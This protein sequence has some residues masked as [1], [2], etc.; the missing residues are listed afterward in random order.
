MDKT[1]EV[2]PDY[3]G[4][5]QRLRQRF[6]K[7]EGQDMADYELLELVLMMS[8]PRRD[9]KPLAKT[10]IKKFGSF[11]NTIN[12]NADDLLSVCGIKENS[13]TLIKVIKTA[14]LRTSWQS[15]ADSQQPVIANYDQLVEYCRQSMSFSDVEELRIIFL[16]CKMKIISQELMQKGT[17]N[18]VA[19]HP[20]EV[21]KAAM[22]KNASSIIMVHN[23]PSGDVTPSKADINITKQIAEAC[24]AVNIKLEDHLVISRN[25]CFS[26]KAAFILK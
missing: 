6:L 14:S 1:K 9:V 19:I 3:L 20:R 25:D 22:N 16:D 7:N 2:E 11:A 18:Q 4:H 23:H 12:A 13:L 21:I 5:R 17:L 24:S 10:L 26:F 15:L 8:I